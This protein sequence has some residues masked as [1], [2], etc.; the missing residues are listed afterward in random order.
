MGYDFMVDT[1]LNVWLIEVNENPCLST[2]S[3]EQGELIEKLVEDTLHL[4]IDSLFGI[5]PQTREESDSSSSSLGDS[6]AYLEVGLA[7]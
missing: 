7:D 3:Q 6:N 1:D 4:T 5:K 2:L